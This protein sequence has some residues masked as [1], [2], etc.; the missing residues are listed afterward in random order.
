MHIKSVSGY[1]DAF[2]YYASS[3]KR[4]STNIIIHFFFS[5]IEGSFKLHPALCHSIFRLRQDT[6]SV[7]SSSSQIWKLSW[8]I[9][10]N[11]LRDIVFAYSLCGI[12]LNSNTF[13]GQHIP[14]SGLSLNGCQA[15]TIC[16][17]LQ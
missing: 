12:V 14:G 16:C 10:S 13:N 2:I 8:L 11:W 3:H 17:C 5:R 7:V 4:F 9:F 6:C 15:L 1:Y